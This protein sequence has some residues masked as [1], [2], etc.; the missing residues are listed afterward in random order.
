MNYAHIYI[1]M[2]RGADLEFE[3]GFYD[4]YWLK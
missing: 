1:F 4:Q 2:I 3:W